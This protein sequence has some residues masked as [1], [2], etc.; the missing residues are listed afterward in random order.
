MK[1]IDYVIELESVNDIENI[2]KYLGEKHN[3]E[4]D[5]MFFRGQKDESWPLIPSVERSHK[6]KEPK[7]RA[8]N[9][10]ELFRGIAKLQ[11][12]GRPTRFLDYT[13]DLFVALFFACEDAETCEVETNGSLYAT[14]YDYR[15]ENNLDVSSV[16]WLT[17]LKKPVK[18]K[19]FCKKHLTNE[20]DDVQDYISCLISFINNG[21]IV[22]PSDEFYNEAL[23]HNPNIFAQRGCFYIPGNRLDSEITSIKNFDNVKILPK[24]ELTSYIL[25]NP[26]YTTK[27][28]IPNGIKKDILN[29]LKTQ[30]NITRQTL[31]FEWY[32]NKK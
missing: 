5:K 27:F 28:I 1:K 26:K 3:N 14:W 24:I 31:F 4:F 11:H 32:G 20:Y 30:K 16:C 6:T 23:S 19:D 25:T 22:K 21:F 12:T 17:Q 18:I 15:P 2:L 7:I 10:D 13:S 29:Y 8:N 9:A